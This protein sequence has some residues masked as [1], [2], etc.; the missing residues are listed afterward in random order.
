LLAVAQDQTTRIVQQYLD[1]L[2]VASGDTSAEPIVRELLGKSVNRL[3][4]LCATMLYRS[5]PRLAQPPLN[6]RPEE[7]LSSVVERMLKAMRHVQPQGVRQFFA[8]ANQ[9]MRW[10]LNDLA[11]RLDKQIAEV[12]VRESVAAAPPESSASQLSPSSRRIL[13]AIEGL[14]SEER[15]A[16]DLVR[17]QGMTYPEAAEVLGV[18]TK[19]VQRRLNRGVLLLTEKLGDL[20]PSPPEG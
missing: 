5:Y 11:R 15:E 16:F 18:S 12:E 9:H 8:L 2:A 19:T 3:H 13:D 20:Q 14:P 6:L 7:M 4:Q 1:E 10:E 17:I